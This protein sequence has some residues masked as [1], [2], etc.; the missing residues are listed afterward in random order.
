LPTVFDELRIYENGFIYKGRKGIQSSL[1]SQIKDHSDILDIGNRL[2]IASIEKKNKEQITFAYKMRGLDVLFHEFDEYEFSKIPESEKATAE[3]LAK[4]PK[5]LG[6]IKATYHVKN[7]LFDLFPLALL[8]LVAGFGVLMP[9]ANNNALLIP[10]C[11]VP[12][13][14]PFV[15]YLWTLIRTKRDELKIFENGFTY[16]SRKELVSCLW[17]EIEDYSTVRRSTDISGIKKEYGPW[18]SLASNMQGTDELRP[19]LRTLVKW[20]GPEE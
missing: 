4:Q 19:Y 5:T 2:K 20:T 16:Q 13:A 15:V 18:I 17:D 14:I 8:L 1:W 6:E 12:M 7:T 3:D 9:V 11:S 10:V